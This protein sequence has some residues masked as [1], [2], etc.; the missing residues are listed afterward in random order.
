MTYDRNVFPTP[1]DAFKS[2]MEPLKIRHLTFSY[3]PEDPAI[4]IRINPT[5]KARIVQ[6]P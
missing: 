5:S 3:D 4:W 2:D 6:Q 1:A